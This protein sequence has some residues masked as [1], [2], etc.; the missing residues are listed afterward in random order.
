VRGLVSDEDTAIY[1]P[2]LTLLTESEKERLV[3]A[4]VTNRKDNMAQKTWSEDNE[5]G[6]D[7]LKTKLDP[8]HMYELGGYLQFVPVYAAVVYVGA[9][10]VQQ[11]IRSLFAPAYII[12]AI[13]LFG[14]MAALIAAGP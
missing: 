6:Y 1:N 9:I 2:G 12:G 3:D 8:L 13:A 11:N 5:L 4:V 10:F 14:P 7:F